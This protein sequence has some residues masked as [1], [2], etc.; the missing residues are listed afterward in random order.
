MIPNAE[1][2]SAAVKDASDM[3][4]AVAIDCDFKDD[5]FAFI[6][7]GPGIVV[8]LEVTPEMTPEDVFVETLVMISLSDDPEFNV[9]AEDEHTEE[10]PINDFPQVGHLTPAQRAQTDTWVGQEEAVMAANPQRFRH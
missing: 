9:A 3:C 5:V 2:Y 8:G 6:W 10:Y 7:C 4:G 1:A